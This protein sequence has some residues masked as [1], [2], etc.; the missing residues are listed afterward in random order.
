MLQEKTEGKGL[1]RVGW[2]LLSLPFIAGGMEAARNPGHR[3]AEAAAAG[4]PSPAMA[5]RANGVIMFVAGIAL[6][7]GKLPRWAA[8][9]LALVLLPTTLVGHAFW[10]ESDPQKRMGQLT[11][12]LKNLAMIGGLLVVRDHRHD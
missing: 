10:K 11:H 8:A 5:V 4:V 2:L 12:F 9:V 7:L 3:V 6:A 1:E